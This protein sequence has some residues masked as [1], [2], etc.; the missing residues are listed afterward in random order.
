[1]LN[2]QGFITFHS[3]GQTIMYPWAYTK[4][5]LKDYEEHHNI[6]KSMSLK[7]FHTTS[8]IYKV[9]SAS[10]VLYKVSGKIYFIKSILINY[11]L[12]KVIL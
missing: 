3:Y 7:I 1:M 9:G 12:T 11:G 8:K 6:A 5:H 2:K 4:T 10:T